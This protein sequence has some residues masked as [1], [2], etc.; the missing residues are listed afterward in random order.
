MNSSFAPATVRTTPSVRSSQGRG[1]RSTPSQVPSRA[2][3]NTDPRNIGSSCG[4][5]PDRC[6]ISGEARGG[7]EEDEGSDDAR[8]APRFLPAP[9]DDQRAEEYPA[10]GAGE[11]GK[12][13]KHSAGGKADPQ[14]RRVDGLAGDRRRLPQQPD[15]GEPQ[16]DSDQRLV[17]DR[18]QVDSAADERRWKRCCREREQ[19]LP[20]RQAAAPVAPRAEPGDEQ[21]ERERRRLHRFRRDREQRHR[22]DIGRGAAVADARVEGGAKREHQRQRDDRRSIHCRG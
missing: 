18:R 11:T 8:S 13:A 22:R 5:R 12:E 1:S 17:I 7:I 10:P 20:V 9:E 6:G 21:V 2:P 14:P 16:E 15:R 4:R 3:A 19:E